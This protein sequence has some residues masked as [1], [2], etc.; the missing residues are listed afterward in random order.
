MAILV[1]KDTKV[2]VQGLTGS[3]GGQGVVPSAATGWRPILSPVGQGSADAFDG[4]QGPFFELEG[5]EAVGGL[6]LK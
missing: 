4:L 2:I 3:A 6:G 5:G 1:D